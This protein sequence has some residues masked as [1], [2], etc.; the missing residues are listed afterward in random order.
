MN[1]PITVCGDIHGQFFDLLEIFKIGGDIPYTNYLFL[2][3]YVDR[4]YYSIECISLLLCLKIRYPNRIYLIR[5]NHESRQITQVYGFYDEC[6]RKY[7]NSN[8]YKYFTDL[9]DYLPL[10]TIIEN[11]IFCVH[12][13]LS[14]SIET[15][16]HIQKLYR[17]QETPQEGPLCDLLWTD[18]ETDEGFSGWVQSPK[19]SGYY[20]GYEISQNFCNDNNLSMICRAHQMQM[21]GYSICHN[22]LCCTIFSAP[23]YC[24]RCGNKAAIMEVDEDINY[25]FLQFNA[26]PIQGRK[27]Y[28]RGDN[29]KR[30][31]DYFL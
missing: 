23:N 16:E 13:G 24:Y 8:V 9:F 31:V 4:G 11:K 21:K 28:N 6:I 17:I 15:I 26:S 7:G 14:P 10:A 1:A 30:C 3:D 18:P 20:F 2:G 12:G 27:D 19:G 5:G 25:T 29:Y 22:G